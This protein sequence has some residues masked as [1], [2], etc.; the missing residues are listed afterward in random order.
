MTQETG[1]HPNGAAAAKLVVS[2]PHIVAR[3]R[4]MGGY[5]RQFCRR[6]NFVRQ[7]SRVILADSPLKT[8]LPGVLKG[9][10][11]GAHAR[12]D[13]PGILES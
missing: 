9:V 11:F 10:D 6:R 1:Q 3:A 4:L 13:R 12:Q 2:T 8:K 7:C 5:L